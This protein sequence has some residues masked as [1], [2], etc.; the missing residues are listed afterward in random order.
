[1]S[2]LSRCADAVEKFLLPLVVIAAAAGVSFPGPGR[3]ADAADA[4][5]ITLAVLVFCTGAAMTFGEITAIRTAGRRVAVVLPA[6]TV[7]LPVL[8]WLAGHLVS[9]TALRE[10]ILCAGIAPA[11][12]ASV[13]LTGLAGGEAALAAGLLVASTAATVLL[14]GPILSLTGSHPS[15]SSLGLLATLALVVAVPLIAGSAMR[16]VD[17][18]GGRDQPVTRMLGTFSLLVLLWEV[19]SQLQLRAS[20]TRVLLALLSYLTGSA[21][22]GW[23]LAIGASPARRTAIVLPVAMRDF[24]VAAGVAASAFGA[25]AAAPLGIYGLLVLIFGSAAVYA[26]RLGLVR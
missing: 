22:L 11:E 4:I 2:L 21:M 17:P 20:D 5:L 19:A 6:S 25:A 3:R 7:G 1:V 24:A 10:G 8:A 12:V 18:F 14:A 26:R 16:S 23:L 15:V 13:A 9:G